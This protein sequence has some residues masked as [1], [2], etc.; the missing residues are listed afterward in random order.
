M[1]LKK[2]VL[3]IVRFND[4]IIKLGHFNL[5]DILI[6]EK[7]DGN[8]LIYNMSYRTLIDSKP[9]RIRFLKLHGIIRIY[10]GIRYLTLFGWKK[11][12]AIYNRVYKPKK[13]TSYILSL[14]FTKIKVDSFD[15]LRP[16]ERLALHNI[17]IHIK[18]HY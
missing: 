17:I 5:N 8:I 14:Y 7:S 10:D 4:E 13:V 18:N 15:S 12:E 6:D 2:F 3:K 1:N 9:L 11:Y 16:E